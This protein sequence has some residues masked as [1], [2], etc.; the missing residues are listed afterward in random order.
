MATAQQFLFILGA[1]DPE[2]RRIEEIL[3]GNANC[4]FLY[5]LHNWQRCHPG[6]AYQAD[7]LPYKLPFAE[8]DDRQIVLVECQPSGIPSGM[9]IIRID[10]HRPGDPGYSLPPEGFWEASSIGQIH[11][12]L[13]L[14]TVQHGDIVLAAMDHNPAGAIRGECPGVLAEEV[15]DRKVEEISKATGF[16]KE[17]V[18]R[19]IQEMS[20]R[21]EKAP[22]VII[23]GQ[24]LKDLRQFYGIGYSVELLSLQVVILKS[25]GGALLSARDADGRQKVT[26][27]G[28]CS[29]ACIEAFMQEWAPANGLTGIYGVPSRGYAGGYPDK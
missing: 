3:F 24:A 27:A 7:P 22:E 8:D 1:E 17:T 14:P 28:H 4:C 9:E 13:G 6:N 19:R 29:P 18:L 20:D 26:V 21:L 5:A 16:D 12:L 15:I 25:G 11:K 23:G 2:M 10:H